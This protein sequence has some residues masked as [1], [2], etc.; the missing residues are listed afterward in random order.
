MAKT[1][2]LKDEYKLRELKTHLSLFISFGDIPN[3]PISR[4]LGLTILRLKNLLKKEDEKLEVIVNKYATLLEDGSYMGIEEE[5]KELDSFGKPIKKRKIIGEEYAY[6]DI[7]ISPENEISYKKEIYKI[8]DS[9]I[10]FEYQS[11]NCNKPT[12]TLV[13]REFD[14]DGKKKV[15]QVEV[16]LPLIEV[17]EKK[18]GA[19]VIAFLLETILVSKD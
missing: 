1:E 16:V 9:K 8:L 7:F 5:T 3:I 4:I 6:F 13:P 15:Y 14:E 2:K 12:S 19:N 18:V 17:L 10:K 11:T